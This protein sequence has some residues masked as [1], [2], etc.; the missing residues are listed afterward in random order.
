M[1]YIYSISRSIVTT[2]IVN[3]LKQKYYSIKKIVIIVSYCS[4][5]RSLSVI[6]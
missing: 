2:A 6:F 5:V 3:R 1:I 4:D